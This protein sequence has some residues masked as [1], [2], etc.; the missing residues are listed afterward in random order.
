MPYNLDEMKKD[1][2]YI[3]KR[4]TFYRNKLKKAKSEDAKA[5]YTKH[6]EGLEK[7]EKQLLVLLEKDKKLNNSFKK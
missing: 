4:V 1:Y 2:E 3:S 6:L 5:L 7:T